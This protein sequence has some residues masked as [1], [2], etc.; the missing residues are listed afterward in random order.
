MT[1]VPRRQRTVWILLS[2]L[3]MALLL[4]AVALGDVGQSLAGEW[5]GTIWSKN[6]G[7]GQARCTLTLRDGRVLGSLSSNFP[8]AGSSR[9]EFTAA[10]SEPHR[11]ITMLT[12]RIIEMSPKPGWQFFQEDTLVY[13]LSEDGT[14]LEG[15][16][17][18]RA[19]NDYGSISLVRQAAPDANAE[20][21]P[22][23]A[24][25]VVR[26]IGDVEMA[27]AGANEWV[28]P[29]AGMVLKRGDRIRTERGTCLLEIDYSD[30]K[31]YLL[32]ENNSYST[33]E[34]A[35]R[36]RPAALLDWGRARS[37]LP[38][39]RRNETYRVRTPIAVTAVRG[40]DFTVEAAGEDVSRYRVSVYEG[41][42]EL[43]SQLTAET[44]TI[45]AGEEGVL[46]ADGQPES[47][48]VVG[49]P[50]PAPVIT[51]FERR[52]EAP[53]DADVFDYPP[54]ARAPEGVLIAWNAVGGAS[55]YRLTSREVFESDE[56]E[57]G[58]TT[59]NQVYLRGMVDGRR[60]VTVWAENDYGR[61][62][63]AVVFPDNLA[64]PVVEESST[65][66]SDDSPQQ[67]T[68]PADT[69]DAVT[70]ASSRSDA[71]LYIGPDDDAVEDDVVKSALETAGFSLVRSSALPDTLSDFRGVIV[72][73]PQVHRTA[74]RNRA[75]LE[76]YIARGGAVILARN[77]PA[78]LVWDMST[79]TAGQTDPTFNGWGEWKGELSG[80]SSWYGASKFTYSTQ[81][82]SMYPW[83][84]VTNPRVVAS[85]NEFLSSRSADDTR[86]LW[87]ASGTRS[88]MGPSRS[89]LEEYAEIH[90][91]YD[92]EDMVFAVS[93]PYGPGRVYYQSFP[94]AANF[95]RVLEMFVSGVRWATRTD[96]QHPWLGLELE[97]PAP[98][99]RDTRPVDGLKI[100]QLTKGG[101]ADLAGLAVGDVITH[102]NGIAIT[103]VG[104]FRTILRQQGV[105]AALTLRVQ[106]TTG[107]RD[108]T[109]TTTVRPQGWA[110]PQ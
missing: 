32:I 67:P 94:Y 23:A 15:S 24:V 51:T 26:I 54:D 81:A 90:A 109:V 56:R 96:S 74:A 18:S 27:R 57:I 78:S 91:V 25:K 65:A 35:L 31:A 55:H 36:G 97:S 98:W 106:S 77:V 107:A 21:G 69:R 14:R 61:E 110:V 58:V 95:P 108:I 29:S 100:S 50:P 101:P 105:G 103:G 12:T 71:V 43:L 102:V 46:T 83:R 59:A 17:V 68:A 75:L 10:Y 64:A 85:Q 41:Q 38:A 3:L 33:I 93:H 99:L 6:A 80:I 79:H 1:S 30:R 53:A 19:A 44:L 5:K 28:R 70:T 88:V 40:T 37:L 60:Q 84:S 73:S 11:T 62:S 82:S 39:L 4:P 42:V 48:A 9:T 2:A 7:R 13:R 66:V 72:L 52:A 8:T 92:G 104:Q 22:V 86:S 34:S 87:S 49:Q 45:A 89:A 76:Q 47:H 63:S 16:F 20:T